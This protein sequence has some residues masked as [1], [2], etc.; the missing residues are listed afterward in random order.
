MI[1]ERKDKLLCS[2]CSACA[3]RCPTS[4]IIMN[5]D[6]KGFLY[7]QVDDSVCINCHLCED[8]CPFLKESVRVDP[9]SCVAALNPDEEV[10]L[11]SSSGGVFSLIS[12]KVIEQ[13]GVVFGALFDEQWH[14]SHGFVDTIDGL[15]RLRGSKYVQSAIGDSFISVERFLTQGKE[16]VFSGTPCQI[17][18]LRCFLKK[19][20]DNLLLIEVACHGVPSPKVWLEY[21]REEL[22]K[23]IVKEV[24]FRSKTTGWKDYSVR[25]GKKSRRHDYDDYIGCF[26]GNYSLRPS[27]FNCQFKE[28][29]S[30]A[31]IMIADFWGIHAIAPELDDDKG[32]S[33][34]IA[35]TKKGQDVIDSCGM[36]LRD[37]EYSQ[38]AKANPS[39]NHCAQ[40]PNDYDAFWNM[41]CGK[42]PYQAIKKYGRRNRAGFMYGIRRLAREVLGEKLTSKIG[43]IIR[44]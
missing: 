44:K 5:E 27:C 35:Y 30:G 26:L 23:G 40:K 24:V 13:K 14:V 42:K 20:Y 1:L 17:D 3:Q 9:I 2:G 37:F 22:R 21:I 12:Q 4:A 36:K 39:I 33:L 8:V 32:I 41:F 43:K 7:P 29:K 38:V 34:V 10:R 18:G 25:I 28:G 6:T 31:D 15:A 16:V 19:S 11:L